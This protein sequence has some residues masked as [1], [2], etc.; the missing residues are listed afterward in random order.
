TPAPSWRSDAARRHQRRDSHSHR[1]KQSRSFV[2][3]GLPGNQGAD[4]F[5]EAANATGSAERSAAINNRAPLGIRDSSYTARVKT[6]PRSRRALLPQSS[7]AKLSGLTQRTPE[8]TRYV[9]AAIRPLRAASPR[10][11]PQQSKEA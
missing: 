7:S 9:D 10:Y 6:V 5:S 11:K 8:T 4:Q 3:P 1:W 2:F